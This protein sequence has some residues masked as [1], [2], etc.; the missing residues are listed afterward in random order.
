MQLDEIE[1]ELPSV[2]ARSDREHTTTPPASPS[3]QQP[4]GFFGL[5]EKDLDPLHDQDTESEDED[6]LAATE[7]LLPATPCRP[8][9]SRTATTTSN[10]AMS[11]R[12]ATFGERSAAKRARTDDKI[13]F[14]PLIGKL[15]SWG[16]A[17]SPLK[18]GRPESAGIDVL[19]GG[20]DDTPAKA[21]VASASPMRNTYFDEAMA[22]TELETH[23]DG[24]AANDV[25]EDQVEEHTPSEVM[26]TDV[27]TP[28][29]DEIPVTEEDISL[30]AEAHEMSL[31]EPAQVEDMLHDDA[32]SEASQEYGDENAIP[33]DPTLLVPPVTPQRNFSGVREVRTTS[34][35]PLKPADDST[36]RPKVKRRGHSISRLP[37]QRPTQGLQRNATVISY[38]PTKQSRH[39]EEVEAVERGDSAPP[40]TPAKSEWSTAG[41][42]ARTPRRDLNPALLRGAVVFVD[43]HTSEGADA[44]GI[45]VELLAQMGARCVK[46]WAWN[47]SSPPQDGGSR[48][49]ITHVVYKDGGKRT[50]EK[51]RESGGVVQCVGVSWVL[52]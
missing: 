20:K 8:S 34:K 18:V 29:F 32:L 1:P 36:P 26:E 27:L 13:G 14:T 48:I 40:V 28:E 43:V 15:N 11:V 21:P 4:A 2:M 51:V 12:G 37:V 5:R 23:E 19:S 6:E 38:S 30:A 7:T 9:T 52:E 41:T 35:V 45:F 46:T 3:Q 49:G 42:P 10:N 47:P 50:L 22:Q 24:A 44:S 16:T 39:M 25:L 17:L 31:M 33:I